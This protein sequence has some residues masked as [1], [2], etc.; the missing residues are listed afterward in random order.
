MF[1]KK[2]RNG[3]DDATL[4]KLIQKNPEKVALLL[5]IAD[6]MFV[7]TYPWYRQTPYSKMI[8]NKRLIASASPALTTTPLT[9]QSFPNKVK[10]YVKRMNKA[11]ESDTKSK[12]IHKKSEIPMKQI[13]QKYDDKLKRNSLRSQLFWKESGLTKEQLLQQKGYHDLQLSSWV[14]DEIQK[15]T[16]QQRKQLQ[17][18]VST[19]E[20]PISLQKVADPVFAND[21]VIY[22]RDSVQS[23]KKSGYTRGSRGVEVE[24]A[25]DVLDLFYK[26]YKD[27]KHY[28]DHPTQSQ[29][30]SPEQKRKNILKLYSLR[31]AARPQK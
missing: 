22:A 18:F 19:Y 1:T 27:Y 4:H 26:D 9:P 31:K 28:K 7:P 15:M 23:M 16:P 5:A 25:Q 6:E 14:K 30:S 3:T 24:N 12:P 29:S 10:R 20:D 17:Q 11:D 21:G 8:R 13:K 2:N